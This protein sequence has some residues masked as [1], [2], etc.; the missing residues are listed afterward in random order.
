VWIIGTVRGTREFAEERFEYQANFVAGIL[1]IAGTL[2]YKSAFRRSRVRVLNSGREISGTTSVLS[3]VRDEDDLCLSRRGDRS[4][5]IEL[6]SAQMDYLRERCN[7]DVLGDLVG[8]SQLSEIEES[9]VR[10]LYCF[11]E[12]HSDR[13]PVM[14]FLKLWS[15][16]ECFFSIADEEIIELNA[17]GIAAVL[18]H[19]GVIG[20]KYADTKKELKRLYKLRSKG[21]HRA[22]FTRITPRDLD[23]F[24]VWMALL[25]ACIAGISRRGYHS[26]QQLHDR[27]LELEREASKDVRSASARPMGS[28][29]SP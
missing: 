9:I 11:A 17:R 7:L 22:E 8:R 12:A 14:Q 10:S 6:K 13:T 5:D 20:V 3:W 18:A 21:L 24:S 29:G 23:T 19:S 15:C 2:L 4:Q 16:A 27:A 25:I 26:L 1:G 28:E